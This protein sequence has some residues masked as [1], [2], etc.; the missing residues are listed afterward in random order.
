[1]APYI[2]S[3]LLKI[4]LELKP[5][6]GC[7]YLMVNRKWRPNPQLKGFVEAIVALEEEIEVINEKKIGVY[8]EVRACGFDKYALRKVITRHRQNKKLLIKQDTLISTYEQ[9]I[10]GLEYL[11]E[12]CPLDT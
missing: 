4:E 1:M 3:G 10:K 11:G 6:L 7:L 2:N 8:Q 5:T 12:D 9:A